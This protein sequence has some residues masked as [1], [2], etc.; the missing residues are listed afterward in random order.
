MGKEATSDQHRLSSAEYWDSVLR[1]AQLPRIN[2]YKHYHVT[3]DFLDP[4]LKKEA[5]KSFMEVGAGSSGWLP[6]FAKKY[7]YKVSGLD[8]SEVGCK[9]AEENLRLLKIDYDEMLCQ[10]L[11][12]WSS[13]KRYDIIFSYGVIEH[14]ENP[15]EVIR[16]FHTHLNE[17]GI[18]ITLVPNLNGLM[19]YLSRK[20]V[21]EIFSMHKVIKL[22]ELEQ[23]HV[24]NGFRNI[25]TDYAGRI[26]LAAIPWVRSDHFLFREGTMWRRISLLFVRG[27]N[28]ILSFLDRSLKLTMRS[29]KY[30]P[31]IISVMRK[32]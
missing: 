22:E 8:Y 5:M 9:I 14:F 20:F 1:S 11:F 23:F 17:N 24:Q 26:M 21:P 18:I 6:Y 28:A 12:N 29:W 4:I 15:A 7:G 16:I 27:V 19:G 31:Y 10:D 13:D 2:P 25:R 32:A 30:S 3:M